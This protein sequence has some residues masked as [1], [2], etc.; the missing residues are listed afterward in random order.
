MQTDLHCVRE[1]ATRS[2]A[3]KEFR[4][5]ASTIADR[6]VLRQGN[7][8]SSILKDSSLPFIDSSRNMI[9]TRTIR[10][11]KSYARPKFVLYGASMT[12]FSFIAD[13]W[14]AA[15]AHLYRRKV[16]QSLQNLFSFHVV[17]RVTWSIGLWLIGHNGCR[18]IL[19][20]EAI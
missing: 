13:G 16:P 11:W 9:F 10:T 12:E 8:H 14:G 15:L 7:G 17:L 6:F 5:L 20:S 3:N 1:M 4:S 2:I 19:C 18:Q